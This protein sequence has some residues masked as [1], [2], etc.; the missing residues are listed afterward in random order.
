MAVHGNNN[1]NR[2]WNVVSN[3][4]SMKVRF[5]SYRDAKRELNAIKGDYRTRIL[6]E[7]GLVQIVRA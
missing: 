3:D 1:D 5:G 4:G 2:P 7:R 6:V